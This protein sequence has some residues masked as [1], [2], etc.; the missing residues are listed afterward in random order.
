MMEPNRFS[1][2]T[3]FGQTVIVESNDQEFSF[4]ILGRDGSRIAYMSHDDAVRMAQA[5]I[6]MAGVICT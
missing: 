5:I 4:C 1:A 2:E 6:N 3:E